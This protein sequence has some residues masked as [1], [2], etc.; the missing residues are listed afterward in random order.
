ML[1]DEQKNIIADEATEGFAYG[2]DIGRKLADELDTA[3]YS[4]PEMADLEK[5]QLYAKI[6]AQNMIRGLERG[7]KRRFD[8]HAAFRQD[9][10]ANKKLHEKGGQG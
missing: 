1:T 8:E 3:I 4:Q 6:Y 2:I 10:R 7:F 5:A 9:V